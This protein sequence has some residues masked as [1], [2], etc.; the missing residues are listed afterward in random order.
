AG[1]DPR[2]TVVLL[3]PRAVRPA[4]ARALRRFLDA[5]G[6][7][8]AGGAEEPHWLGE[9]LR[10]PPTWSPAGLRFVRPRAPVPETA[11]VRRVETAR[12]ARGSRAAA[13]P[14]AARV[15]RR[16]RGPARAVARPGRGD[17]APAGRAAAAARAA[18]RGEPVARG[19][20]G[21][22]RG[23]EPARG[24]AGRRARAR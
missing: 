13:A 12:P 8:V 5:G 9:V 15:R 2:S 22:A 16:P 24:R 23:P 21:R 4:D 3:D 18:G 11:G 10:R 7:L 20:A 17:R 6:R 19:G 1:L 14:A